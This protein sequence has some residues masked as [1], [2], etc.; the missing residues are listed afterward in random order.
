MAEL[1]TKGIKIE[2]ISELMTLAEELPDYC[3]LPVLN[4]RGSTFYFDPFVLPELEMRL[5]RAELRRVE[6]SVGKQLS[7]KWL[8]AI[9]LYVD[10]DFGEDMIEFAVEFY[11]SGA[12]LVTWHLETTFRPMEL[13][14]TRL[15]SDTMQSIFEAHSEAKY[16][17]GY[18]GDAAVKKWVETFEYQSRNAILRHLILTRQ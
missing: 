2:A 3:S 5:R 8:A 12:A 11:E 6:R 9:Q 13:I 14:E 18:D 10:Y 16:L 4:G 1:A 7:D 15:D 17:V